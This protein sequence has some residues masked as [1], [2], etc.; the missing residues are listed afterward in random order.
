M[1]MK[2]V[3]AYNEQRLCFGGGVPLLPIVHNIE[4]INKPLICLI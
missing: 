3:Y 1:N 2:R 4:T